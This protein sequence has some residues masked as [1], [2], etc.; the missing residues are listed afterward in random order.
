MMNR[1]PDPDKE[2][3]TRQFVLFNVINQ[4]ENQLVIPVN[5]KDLILWGIEWEAK[6]RSITKSIYL[7]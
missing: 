3:L 4:V 7:T 6:L 5:M 1:K 2:D